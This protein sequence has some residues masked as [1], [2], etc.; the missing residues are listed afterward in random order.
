M[1]VVERLEVLGAGESAARAERDEPLETG[2]LVGV[3]AGDPGVWSGVVSG[4]TV[5]LPGVGWVET[6]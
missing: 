5:D 6:C 1:E 4:G 3:E 2:E